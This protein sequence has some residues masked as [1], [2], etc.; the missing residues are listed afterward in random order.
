MLM[1][2]SKIYWII[3]FGVLLE[4]VSS[5]SGDFNIDEDN[6][7]IPASLCKMNIYAVEI[8]IKIAAS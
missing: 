4:K 8:R 1:F 7:R 5:C 6:W 2:R 3:I